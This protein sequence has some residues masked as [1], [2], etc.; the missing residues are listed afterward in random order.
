VQLFRCHVA[1]N[2]I[3]RIVNDAER[4]PGYAAYL[5][6]PIYETICRP[7]FRPTLW[8]AAFAQA[9]ELSEGANS[10]TQKKFLQLCSLKLK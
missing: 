4:S 1:A 2:A 8:Q 6:G 10:H 3:L 7:F 5:F 9:V